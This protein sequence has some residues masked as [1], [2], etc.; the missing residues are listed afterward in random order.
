MVLYLHVLT[1]KVSGT[2]SLRLMTPHALSVSAEGEPIFHVQSDLIDS[3]APRDGRG[4][5]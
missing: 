1:K 5:G 3:S 2:K 4:F